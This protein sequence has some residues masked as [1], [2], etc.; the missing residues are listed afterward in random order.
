MLS[1]G[2]LV[3]AV[4]FRGGVKEQSTWGTNETEVVKDVAAVETVRSVD[5]GARPEDPLSPTEGTL[6]IE[7]ASTENSSRYNW[8]VSA[9]SSVSDSHPQRTPG[10]AA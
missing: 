7:R 4:D 5:R 10:G 3:D 2:P 6:T 1:R 8:P 9:V